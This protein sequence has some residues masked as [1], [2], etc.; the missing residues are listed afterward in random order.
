[1][2][3]AQT[4]TGAKP[5]LLEPWFAELDRLC[6]R[7]ADNRPAIEAHVNKFLAATRDWE[8]AT[9][10]SAQR[11]RALMRARI[12]RSL[13]SPWPRTGAQTKKLIYARHMIGAEGRR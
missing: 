4:P 3:G 11:Y 10:E 13:T 9:G 12:D 5:A 8:T 1:V 7:R 6:R 2:A